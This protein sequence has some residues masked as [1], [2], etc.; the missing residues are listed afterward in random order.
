MACRIRILIVFIILPQIASAG[1]FDILNENYIESINELPYSAGIPSVEWQHQSHIK[2]WVDIVGFKNLTKENGVYFIQGDP[3]SLAIVQ[4]GF[5]HDIENNVDSITGSLL[6][7][8]SDNNLIASLTVVLKWHVWCYSK[9]S[10]W[11]CGRLT[12]TKTFQDT[13][14]IPD[15]FDKHPNPTVNIIE[16]NNTIEPKI[17]IT[18]I[19]PNA[20]KIFIQYR[21]KSITERL[22]LYHVESTAK[23]VYYANI[24]TIESWDVQG[25]SRFGN[26]ALI[27]TNISDMNYSQLNITVMDIYGTVKADTFNIKQITY[28]PNKIVFNALLFGFMGTIFTLFAASAYLIGRIQF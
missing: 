27:N 6:L 18:V 2:S 11:I 7:S 24:S 12:E 28:E 25:I 21:N 8:Q 20:S 13:E 10:S 19:E 22:K 9:T 4:Y 5:E 1:L 26:S 3:A 15:Q 23:G 14:V 17:S 16:Y